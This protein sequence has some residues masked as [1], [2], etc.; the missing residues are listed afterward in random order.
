MAKTAR[1]A[2]RGGRHG[3]AGSAAARR[4]SNAKRGGAQ[5]AAKWTLYA[6]AMV[7]GVLALRLFVNA[8]ELLPVNFDEAQYWAYGQELD[9]GYFSKPP[10]VGAVI[11]LATDLGGNSLFTL[12]LPSALAHALIA[13]GLFLLGRRLFDAATG[14]WAAAA[15]TAAPGVTVSAMIMSTD[16]VMMAA[17]IL[18][19]IFWA[20]AADGGRTTDWALMGLMIGLGALAKYT[21][22]AMPVAAVGYGLF[23]A[24]G[25]DW[26][27]AGNAAA[28]AML[29]LSPNLF[30]NASNGFA[31]V[32]HVAED[33]DPGKGYFNPGSLAEFMGAQLGVIGPVVFVAILVAFWRR[34][35][36]IGDWRMRMLAWQ[37]GL[38]LFTIIALSFLTR[39][40]PNWAAPAY[41]AG[42][43]FAVAWLRQ[44]GF[45]R[46][47]RWQMVAGVAGAVLLYGLAA[48]YAGRADT[49]LR[50]TDPY[51]KMRLSEPFCDR[52]LAAMAEE[53][54]D[55]LLSTSRKRLSEC[56]FLG[57]LGWDEVAIWHPRGRAANHHEMAAALQPGDERRMLV[58]VMGDAER[59]VRRF[60][61]AREVDS[62]RFATH[63]DRDYG[64][65]LWV[66]EGFRGYVE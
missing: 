24:R 53:G 48:L 8:L 46:F 62:G 33:A 34:R 51:K 65:S 6:L 54:A 1:A 43:L 31:T 23:S 18:A 50:P 44:A 64:Y 42:S 52:A 58:A 47:L 25:R 60:E 15:Y 2:G 59:I 13:G 5:N 26:R 35:D 9:W 39:A 21:M 27:G 16:P 56:M 38:L 3:A 19:M 7:A 14:F 30:W 12:R 55:V 29:V 45:A 36:W 10:G 40:Q 57:S 11:R 17:W 41:V 37:T 63:R 28:V 20:R 22:L 4:A 32:F 66:V 61:A 49:L